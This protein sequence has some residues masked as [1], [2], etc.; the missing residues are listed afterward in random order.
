KVVV[1]TGAG[2]SFSAGLDLT[3]LLSLDT[4]ARI[5]YLRGFFSVF[6]Q[7]YTLQ[8]PVIAS[9][10]GAAIA[11]GFD[12]AVACDIRLCSPEATFAQTEI[13]LGLTQ[14]LYPLYKLVGLGRAKELAMTG[15]PITADEAYRIGLVNHVYPAATLSSETL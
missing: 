2:V 6:R 5:Q 7:V 10:N 14:F 9:I 13:L 8:Q 11:G 1:I 3:H 15:R 4:N 12:L